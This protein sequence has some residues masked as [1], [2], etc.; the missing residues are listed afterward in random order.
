MHPHIAH[1]LGI[2]GNVAKENE[3][4]TDKQYWHQILI[5]IYFRH[6]ILANIYEQ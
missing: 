3:Y 6:Q 2:S 5:N 1:I 4:A